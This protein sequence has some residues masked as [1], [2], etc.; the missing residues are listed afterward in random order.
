MDLLIEQVFGYVLTDVNVGFSQAYRTQKV[1]PLAMSIPGVVGGEPWG[2]ALGSVLTADGSTGTQ[3]S[4]IAPP[5]NSTLI[6]PTMTTG[7]WLVPED[8]HAI[9]IGNHLLAVRP[10]LKVGDQVTIDIDG[11]Q[12]EWTIVGMYRMGGTAIPPI[13][14]TNQE[15]FSKVTGQINQ[16]TNCAPGDRPT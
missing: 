2:E 12:H 15:Y 8:E 6:E 16:A 14:Y 5:A 9:V 10:E 3:V 7:R 11:E 13:I 4:I 1:L